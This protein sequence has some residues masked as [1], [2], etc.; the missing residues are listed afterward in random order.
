MISHLTLGD[1]ILILFLVCAVLGSFFVV[2]A[3]AVPGT[4]VVVQVDG[5]MVQKASLLENRVIHVR[6]AEGSLTVEIKEGRVSVIEAE[7]PNHVCIRTGWRSRGGDV[8]VCVPNKCVV[9]ILANDH[10]GV[11]AVTG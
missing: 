9:R 7:C 11:R 3:W 5:K 2:G 8:I 4:T 1:K 10:E 6:G